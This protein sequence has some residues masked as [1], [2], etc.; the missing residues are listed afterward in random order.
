MKLY[1]EFQKISKQFPSKRAINDY[2]F[3]D[4]LELI[5][6][7]NYKFISTTNDENIIID[8]L[9]ASY[10]N[11]P[12]IIKPK[13]DSDNLIL[14]TNVN[15][16]FALYLYSSGSSGAPRKPIK[17]SE[18]MILK[19][20]AV[21]INSQQLNSGDNIFT[22]CSLNHTGGINAQTI[23][24]LLSGASVIIK[25]FNGFSFFRDVIKYKITKTHLIPAMI[26]VLIKLDNLQPG[27][28]KLVVAGS[29]CIKK[30]HVDFF[31]KNDIKFMCNYGLTE[32]GPIILNHIFNER[33]ELEIFN[34][35]VPLGDKFWCDYQILNSELVLRG[36]NVHINDWYYTG[37]CVHQ[38]DNWIFYNGRL[39]H[40]CKIIPK[41]YKI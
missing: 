20:S 18:E 5:Q 23:P 26:D 6:N 12:L 32:A 37:D 16:S 27:F 14:P 11:L 28:L 10:K 39:S 25:K 38:I 29:D 7:K 9:H 13:Y 21:A 40:D 30:E 4:L 35:G 17:I 31:L 2:S 3:N 24:A 22:I 1:N 19:N 8:I 33:S 36:E 34:Y 15:D 41:K